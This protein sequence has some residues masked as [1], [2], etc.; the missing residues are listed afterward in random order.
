MKKRTPLIQP[1]WDLLYPALIAKWRK[2][3]KLPV[4]PVKDKLQT[5]EFQTLIQDLLA[6]RESKDLSTSGAI[7]A[8]FMYEWPLRYAEA[9]SLLRELPIPPTRTL[10]IGSKGSPFSLAALQYGATEAFSVDSNERMQKQGAELCGQMGYPISCRTCDYEKIS[11][12]PIEGKWDLIILPYSLF[13]LFSNTGERASYLQKLLY[14]LTPQGHLLLVESSEEDTNRAFL[15][16]RDE[17]VRSGISIT[18]PCL[19][20]GNCPALHSKAPCYAQRP[21]DKPFMI[22]EIQRACH[23]NLSSLKMSY[24]LLPSPEAPI[25]TLQNNLY[26]VVSPPVHTFKGERFFLCGVK[27]KKTLGSTLQ[28][29]PKQSKAFAFLK[30]GD[31]IA[32]EKGAELEDDIQVTEKTTLELV[33]PCDKPLPY[34]DRC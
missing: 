3:M 16:L 13:A 31:V 18:A 23:I 25:E 27:G 10:E 9:L 29:H 19:W 2:L 12:L 34:N 1:E 28:E 4:S 7:A 33:A 14:L 11:T 20:K 8:Y 30:R 5:R 21:L 6:Y 17:L 32:I 26:R 22:K 15:S 24:L